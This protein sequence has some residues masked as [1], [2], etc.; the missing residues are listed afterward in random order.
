MRVVSPASPIHREQ[1]ERGVAL[2]EAEGYK[3][4]FAEHAFESDGYLA[5][6]DEH[7]AKDLHTAFQDPEV[8]CVLCSRGGYG[9]SRLLPM[10]DLDAMAASGKMFCGFSD[11][12]VLHMALNRRGLVTMHTPMLLTLSVDREQWVIDSFT[13]L[14]KGIAETPSNA[15]RAKTLVG[16]GA[17]GV[18]AGGCLCLITDCIATEAWLSLKDK[19]VLIEDVDESPHRIDA[20]LT[21]LINT[22]D[23]HSARGIVVGEMTGTDDKIDPKI[24]A[25]DWRRIVEDRVAPLGIPAVVDF[26]FGHMKT[27]LSLPLGVEAN[28]DA[29]A[30]TLTYTQPPCS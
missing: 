30:G 14:L 19:I 11:V 9:I 5:G 25:W 24:G 12:T 2:L 16:G 22:G 15:K 17:S 6:S 4:T 8:A 27:M 23:L 10:L 20:M 18:V 26:P 1:T 7:R 13:A 28:L 3:V 29:D 21:H